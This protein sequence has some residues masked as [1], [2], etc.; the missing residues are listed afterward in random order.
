MSGTD[1]H[2]PPSG[3]AVDDGKDADD[4]ND[5]DNDEGVDVASFINAALL[6]RSTRLRAMFTIGLIADSLGFSLS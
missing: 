3:G 1:T 2:G 5:N 6:T 4:D